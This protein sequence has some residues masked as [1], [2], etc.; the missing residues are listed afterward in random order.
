[1]SLYD[2]FLPSKSYDMRPRDRQ[3]SLAVFNPDGEAIGILL[4][5]GRTIDVAYK[6][7]HFRLEIDGVTGPGAIFIFHIRELVFFADGSH[8]REFPQFLASCSHGDPEIIEHIDFRELSSA[9]N[10]MLPSHMDTI[11]MRFQQRMYA[12]SYRTKF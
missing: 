4:L 1:M 2:P 8:N 11:R 6:M 9:M 3:R 7:R 10:N 5:N 12:P